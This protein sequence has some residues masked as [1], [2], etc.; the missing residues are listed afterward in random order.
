MQLVLKIL[1]TALYLAA[2]AGPAYMMLQIE[3]QAPEGK[4]ILDTAV[5]GPY[6]MYVLA[7]SVLALVAAVIVQA[8]VPA[9]YILAQNPEMGAFTAIGRSMKLMRGH[10]LE[11]LIFRLS[12]LPWYIGVGFTFGL[13]IIYLNPLSEFVGGDVRA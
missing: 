10:K 4:F 7:A 9:V 11:Y 6:S 8:W 2:M 5:A 3:K 12:F 1:S 13:L